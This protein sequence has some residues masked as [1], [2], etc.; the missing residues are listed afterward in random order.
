MNKLNLDCSYFHS[1]RALTL[2]VIKGIALNSITAKNINIINEQPDIYQIRCHDCNKVNYL[3]G[4]M[5][6][7]TNYLK[8]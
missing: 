4:N 3:A 8:L 1:N 2:Q 6:S 5:K 7:I